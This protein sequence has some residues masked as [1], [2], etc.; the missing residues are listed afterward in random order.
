[1]ASQNPAPASGTAGI[2]AAKLLPRAVQAEW[3]RAFVGFACD[4]INALFDKMS[5]ALEN[6]GRCPPE[7]DAR[8]LPIV[9]ALSWDRDSVVTHVW[10]IAKMDPE[11]AEDAF[12]PAVILRALFPDDADVGAWLVTLPTKVVRALEAIR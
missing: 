1:M 11:R 3:K 9:Q 12:A 4:E 5:A 10:E 8:L 7:L 2:T 6:G